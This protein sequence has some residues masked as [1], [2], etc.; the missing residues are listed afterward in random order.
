MSL[1]NKTDLSVAP[2]VALLSV[3]R[4]L[5]KRKIL[6]VLIWAVT[7]GVTVVYVKKLPS[8]YRAVAV[9]L[10]DNQKIPAAYVSSTVNSSAAD[11]VLFIR[12]QILSNSKI[13]SLADMN[14]FPDGHDL[15]QEELASRIRA[16]LSV[17][18]DK[19]NGNLIRI[20]Y[21]GPD[22]N[23]V[24]PVANKMADIF[25]TENIQ[26]R[27][28]S[29]TTTLEFTDS[30]LDQ[31]RQK[32]DEIAEAQK[33]YKLKYSGELPSQQGQLGNQL[34]SLQGRL[35]NNVET[36]ARYNQQLDSLQITLDQAISDD[37]FQKQ[38]DSILVQAENEMAS[39]RL[40]QGP[41]GQP[42]VPQKASDVIRQQLVG[43]RVS[44]GEDHPAIKK[45]KAALDAALKAEAEQASQTPVATA[46]PAPEAPPAPNPAFRSAS[47]I[48]RIQREQSQRHRTDHIES[49]QTNMADLK[50]QIQVL[51][52][53]QNPLQREIDRLNG[54]LRQLPIREQDLERLS[55]DGQT[56]TMHYQNLLAKKTSAEMSKDLESQQKAE[57]FIR[58]QDASV[59]DAPISPNRPFL[60]GAGASAG[61]LLSVLIGILLEFRKGQILGEWEL[62]K[63]V[64]VLAHLPSIHIE[65]ESSGPLS[66]FRR[67][68]AAGIAGIGCLLATISASLYFLV[69]S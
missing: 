28:V 26:A 3:A 38:A 12:E 54:Q 21:Q 29:T 20:G 36:I 7:I 16:N 24:A 46:T 10:V 65:G 56:A 19:A 62:P 6:I 69:K 1:P 17:D 55:R 68:K 34:G 35:E 15:T 44:Y 58:A 63:N 37:D 39:Q 32:L 43:Y 45:A 14:L 57:N 33:D 5:W 60:W 59:P 27:S 41:N 11:R 13:K 53:Q 23:V 8:V 67:N 48:A 50:K 2:E 61:L 51:T 25:I 31:A 18:I 4:M 9:I 47:E 64:V 42:M 49:I 52:A 40:V 30:E 66:F 22:Q